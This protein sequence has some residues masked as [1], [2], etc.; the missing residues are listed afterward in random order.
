MDQTGR[1]IILGYD[2]VCTCLIDVLCL[3]AVFC[4]LQEYIFWLA[5]SLS[6]FWGLDR[7]LRQ[8]M[9]KAVLLLLNEIGLVLISQIL[10]KCNGL[11]L[12][13]WFCSVSSC[14]ASL[15]WCIEFILRTKLKQSYCE[16]LES[17]A[18]PAVFATFV[19]KLWRYDLFRSGESCDALYLKKSRSPC[20]VLIKKS[21][22]QLGQTRHPPAATPP[23]A[24]APTAARAPP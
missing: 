12:Q 7:R 19:N 15:N 20:S 18:V 5:R 14:N 11:F 8:L 22:F 3:I 17:L 21:I 1:I 24:P 6:W 4:L 13:R 9:I 2:A 16:N 10:V 23:A